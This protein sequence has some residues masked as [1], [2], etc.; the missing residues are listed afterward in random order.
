M[1]AL[2]AFVVARPLAGEWPAAAVATLVAASL[3]LAGTVATVGLTAWRWRRETARAA[4]ED[5]W[6]RAT[7]AAEMGASGD[8]LKT[9]IGVDV[10][11]AM[12]DM[13]ITGPSEDQAAIVI[14]QTLMNERT[15][16][17]PVRGE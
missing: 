10:A 4:R 14:L 13:R 11:A 2:I 17:G 5:R 6:T 3:A 15:Q 7:W 9:T 1:T 12:Y 8:P 16:H